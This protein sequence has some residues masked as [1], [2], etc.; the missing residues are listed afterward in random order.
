METATLIILVMV[1]LAV[2]ALGLGFT[3]G[4]PG[5]RK[6]KS[7]PQVAA[8]AG[9]AYSG[10]PRSAAASVVTIRGR[11]PS[12]KLDD[13]PETPV[14]ILAAGLTAVVVVLL[15]GAYVVWNPA[16]QASAEDS[17][18]HD[19]VVQ[20]GKLYS[21]YC[22]QCHGPSG[23]GQSGPNLHLTDQNG[24]AARNNVNPQNPADMTK[25]RDL[26]VTA[27]SAGRA[28]KL[29]PAWA[30]ENGGPLNQG[31]ISALADLIV[32]NSWQDVAPPPAAT[33]A[34]APVPANDPAVA[35]LAK[36]DC[37]GCHAITG[38]PG[39]TGIVGPNLTH[40]ASV[41]RIPESSGN[42]EN[43]PANLA[44]WIYDAQAVKPGTVMPNMSAQ[45]MSRE[46]AQEIANFLIAINTNGI[47]AAPTATPAPAAAAPAGGAQA[48]APAAPAAAAPPAIAALFTKYGC[49]GCHT[50]STVQGAVGTVGPNLS[51][52]GS[53]PKIPESTGNLDN[54]PD[55]L[56]KWIFNAQAVKPGAVMPNISS[57]GMTPD[58]AKQIA[59][60]LETLK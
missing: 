58:E 28:G 16:R 17:Q 26:V 11:N 55:N 13:P 10:Q 8:T 56:A 5:A 51:H 38:V 23:A 41:P 35:L 44:N 43:T 7:R 48:A 25:L 18:L 53:V 21:T 19:N 45:N 49:V 42:L 52:V 12:V 54:T 39:A 1:L 47:E 14:R 24:L 31:Q 36:Y 60:Y 3:V 37:I 30:Q 57:M 9:S 50:L 59:D 34:G 6:G 2:G 20:G 27:I 32:T 46:E 22:A 4:A 33:P 40:V 15:V 29:M